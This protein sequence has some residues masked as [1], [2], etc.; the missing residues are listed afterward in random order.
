VFLPIGPANCKKIFPVFLSGFRKRAD[1]SAK[2][3]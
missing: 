3:P 2:G 1:S